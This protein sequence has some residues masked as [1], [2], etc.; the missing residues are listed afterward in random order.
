MFGLAQDVHDDR[1][2]RGQ[3]WWDIIHRIWTT[4]APFDFDGAY[5]RL[6]GVAGRPLPWGGR[7][8]ILMNAGHSV[9]G[10]M[11]A[12]RNCDMLFDQP[13]Y[14]DQAAER[15]ADTKKA[16]RALGKE[17][18]VFTS[19]AVVCRPTQK[20]ADAY[21]H[22]FAVENRDDGAIDTMFKLYLNPANERT[23]TRA[24]IEKLRMRYGAG[25]GG[26][27]A[28]GSP[29]AVAAEFKRLADAGFDGFCFSFVA[30]NDE[31]PYFAQE[32]LPRLE[33]LGL[34]QPAP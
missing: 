33:R 19:G 16:A 31:L 26:L 11:F 15:I 12:A 10:R 22:H 29:D 7:R 13:H 2:A 1:Y 24:D 18:L 9:A 25:Y 17:I 28:V 34:R 8:P 20:D 3:E 23:M 32:V 4:D 21:L 5:Y 27:L 14:L 30:Y 6:K